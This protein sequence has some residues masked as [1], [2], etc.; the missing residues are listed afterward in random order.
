MA[1]QRRA[2]SSVKIGR[3]AQRLKQRIEDGEF[4][5]AHQTYKIL[6]QR[7][8]A[9]G[10]KEA[11]LKLLFDGAATLLRHSQVRYDPNRLTKPN[12]P[13]VCVSLSY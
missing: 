5:E 13:I 2:V 4:Y 11:A 9:Q 8:C 10:K 3:V 6:Y 12:W 7:Y 1:T